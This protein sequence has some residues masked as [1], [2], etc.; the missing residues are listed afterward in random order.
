V[1][2]VEQPQKA[3]N[4]LTLITNL[5][6]IQMKDQSQNNTLSPHTTE[7][8]QYISPCTVVLD[9]PIIL[10]V[11]KKLTVGM[12]YLYVEGSHIK[13]VNLIDIWDADN[14]VYIKIQDLKTSKINTVSWS[15]EY[16]GAYY[17]WTLASYSY[18]LKLT[19]EKKNK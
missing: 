6:H 16:S 10:T 17:L 11:D 1:V 7:K 4:Y 5:N 19:G 13:A 15:L 14:Y 8:L 9:L 2:I 12:P 3:T 18:L